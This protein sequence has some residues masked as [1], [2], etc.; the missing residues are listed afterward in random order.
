M[1]KVQREIANGFRS[2]GSATAFP[3]IRRYVFPRVRLASAPRVP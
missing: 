1:L 2:A 3:R